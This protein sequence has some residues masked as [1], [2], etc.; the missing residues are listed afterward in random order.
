MARALFALVA[1]LVELERSRGQHIVLALEPEPGC[2]LETSADVLDFF[3]REVWS[4]PGLTELGR[5]LALDARASEAAVR[6]HLGVCLDACHASVEH[7]APLDVYRALTGAGIVVPKI[8]VSAGLALGQPSAEARAALAAYDEPTYLHQVVVKDGDDLRR[9]V[10]LPDA[11]SAEAGKS[12]DWRVHFHVPVFHS[13]LGEFHSTQSELEDLLLAL[14]RER[15]EV[16]LEVETYTWDVLPAA[17]RERPL[18]EAIALEL[19]WTRA[20]WESAL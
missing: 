7:E 20:A 14:G 12:G 4:G 2:V 11:L 1:D 13:D 5:L 17:L 9:Y 19:E 10:D 3:A 6:R 16:Q 15:V 18:V 8:Q